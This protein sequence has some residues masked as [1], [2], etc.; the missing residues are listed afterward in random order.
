MKEENIDETILSDPRRVFNLDESAFYLH[1]TENNVIAAEGTKNV[2][3]FITSRPQQCLTALFGGNAISKCPPTLILHR[4]DRVP[5][6]FSNNIPKSM[7]TNYSPSGRMNAQ[8]FYDYISGPFIDW[9]EEKTFNYLWHYS[10]MGA[11]VTWHC[12]CGNFARKIR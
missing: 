10:W 12:H 6:H 5:R 7:V 9:I 2:Y 11:R 8:T 3:N 1:P 4:Y